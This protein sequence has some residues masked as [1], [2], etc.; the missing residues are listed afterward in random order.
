MR[1][2]YPSWQQNFRI[3]GYFVYS[4]NLRLE[5]WQEDF[6]NKMIKRRCQAYNE[7]RGYILKHLH[8]A[9]STSECR[10]AIERYCELATDISMDKAVAKKEKNAC[11][12]I[13]RNSIKSYKIAMPTK[14]GKEPT[15][16][17]N[18]SSM[19][20][21]VLFAK[22]NTKCTD[23]YWSG[24]NFCSKS[25]EDSVVSPLWNAFDKNFAELYKH[26]DVSKKCVKFSIKRADYRNC[27]SFGL[28]NKQSSTHE[29]SGIDA[30]V[31]W[32]IPLHQQSVRALKGTAKEYAENLHKRY[33]NNVLFY[34]Y[35]NMNKNKLF[36][37][38]FE[39]KDDWYDAE[40]L[41]CLQN[42]KS[43]VAITI[44][45]EPRLNKWIW[46]I[47]FT[48]EGNAPQRE[49]LKKHGQAGI[50]IGTS[51]IAVVTDTEVY[52]N[53]LGDAVADKPRRMASKCSIKMDELR[54]RDNPQNYNEDGTI[55]KGAK[56]RGWHYS[57]EYE[58]AALKHKA[59]NRKASI[60]TAN[61]NKHV[62]NEISL[63]ADTFNIEKMDFKSLQRR[64]SKTTVNKNGR[65]N[66][67]KRF[68][69]SLLMHS[70]SMAITYLKQKVGAD[71]VVEIDTKAAKASQHNPITGECTPHGLKERFVEVEG[72]KI[73][74]DHL[75]ALNLKLWNNES[76]AYTPISMD[77][78]E[79][80]TDNSMDEM[81]TLLGNKRNGK[82]YPSCMGIKI[83][84]KSFG[85]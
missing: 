39:P 58:K 55:A 51:S 24:I 7:C 12:K 32:Q 16:S 54:R 33:G 1:G 46:R 20:F 50:D 41:R 18:F 84:E 29:V 15:T 8:E 34:S 43:I 71:N 2:R 17:F 69:K 79:K 67:K 26:I 45:K 27:F 83:F 37:L 36:P 23:G 21:S 6:F 22:F 31:I 38:C 60:I 13:I 44:K 4:A 5:K 61:A 59:Y 70:P 72:K 30:G 77:E 53:R 74:R 75:A 19:G 42:E 47:Q 52:H 80:F 85:K 76:N 25:F 66:S 64:S 57:N 11:L 40:A 73:Q 28:G 82:L 48:L 3:M 81:K 62:M 35:N 65:I 63:M 49:L 9:T 78:F 14:K 68:G 10:K 56:K